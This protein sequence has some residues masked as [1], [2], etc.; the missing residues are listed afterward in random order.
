MGLYAVLSGGLGGYKTLDLGGVLRR[1]MAVAMACARWF[2]MDCTSR[3]SS[4]RKRPQSAALEYLPGEIGTLFPA[5][6]IDTAI[7]LGVPA[8]LC[9]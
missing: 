7:I 4:R 5:K 1:V 6:M 2:T 9:S 3:E 8:A